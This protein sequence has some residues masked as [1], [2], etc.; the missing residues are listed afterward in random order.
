MRRLTGNSTPSR[1][2]LPIVPASVLFASSLLLPLSSAAAAAAVA[3]ATTSRGTAA[4]C[5]LNL[6]SL[7]EGDTAGKF[8]GRVSSELEGDWLLRSWL[9]PLSPRRAWQRL[10]RLAVPP[11][12]TDEAGDAERAGDDGRDAGSESVRD[13]CGAEGGGG[14][15]V[16]ELCGARQASHVDLATR[17]EYVIGRDRDSEIKV[18]LEK[19]SW[20]P[21]QH[22]E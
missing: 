9:P 15:E 8:R 5:S 22:R 11:G 12:H 19:K 14:G 6:R 7:L 16:S 20:K 3:T 21:E 4:S 18:K 10:R 1:K 17:K 2:S 13:A